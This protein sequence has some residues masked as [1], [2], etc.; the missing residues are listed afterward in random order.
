MRSAVLGHQ[1]RCAL[2]RLGGRDHDDRARGRAAGCLIVEVADGRS[3]DEV[4]VGD[5]APE[6]PALAAA[7]LDDDAVNRVLRHRPGDLGERR[8]A[9]AGE[10]AAVHRCRRLT[11]EI[12]F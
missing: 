6:R 11:S 12:R 7:A 3:R 10:D 8:L 4:E 1:L 9:L 2:E 5:D